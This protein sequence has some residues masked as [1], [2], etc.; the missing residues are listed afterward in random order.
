MA[1]TQFQR[2]ICRLIAHSRIQAGERYIA[3]GSALNEALDAA[4]LSRDIDL[5][6][7]TAEAVEQSYNADRAL[8]LANGFDV[9]V[10][11]QRR[12]FVEAEVR[13]DLDSVLLQWVQDSAYR[14]FPLVEHT[15][16]GLMLNPFDLATNKILAL[17][18]RVEVRDWVDAITT[19]ERLQPLGLLAWA[20]AGKDPGFTPRSIIEHAARS[21]RYSA[22]EVATLAFDGDPPDAAHSCSA[23]RGRLRRYAC[24]RRVFRPLLPN[25]NPSSAPA[26]CIEPH[27]ACS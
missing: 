5:F 17:V 11:R 7:D 23:S 24:Q 27:A 16:F 22:T 3:G 21:A 8:L 12:A 26:S 19:H 25:S 6:H 10:V 20:A 18:G 4:R 2:V 9:H 14:F 1:L 15:E 13:R